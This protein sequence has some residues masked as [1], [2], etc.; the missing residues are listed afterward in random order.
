MDTAMKA[1]PVYC[2][3]FALH[4]ES[5]LHD[6]G[7]FAVSTREFFYRPACCFPRFDEG[8]HFAS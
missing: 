5:N 2:N 3:Y 4:T 6:T 7:S 1:R 8:A